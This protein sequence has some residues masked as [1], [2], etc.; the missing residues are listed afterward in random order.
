MKHGFAVRTALGDPGSPQ[1]PFPEAASIQAAVGDLLSDGF[2]DAL[3][4]KTQDDDVLPDNQ[5][6]GRWVD[7]VNTGRE[8]LSMKAFEVGTEQHTVA[9]GVQDWRQKHT[10]V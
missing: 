2:V 10:H 5:Y 1:Q 3:R 9:G 4:A 8:S 7:G 6:G